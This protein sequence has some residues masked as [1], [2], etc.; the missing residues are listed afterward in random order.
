VTAEQCDSSEQCV[1]GVCLIPPLMAVAPELTPAE[2]GQPYEAEFQATGGVPPYRW[3]VVE[4][5]L[6]RGLSLSRR[7]YLSGI[8]WTAGTWPFTAEVTDDQGETSSVSVEL[9]VWSLGGQVEITTTALPEASH[10]YEYARQLEAV[11]GAEPYAWQV[12]EGLLPAGMTLSSDG[13]LSGVPSEIG[14]FPL[15]FRVIDGATPPTYDSRE[16]PLVVE[17]SP[18][19][20]TGDREY[21]LLVTKIIILGI[22]VP[23]IPYSGNLEARGGLTPYQWE[24][25]DLPRALRLLVGSGGLPDGLTLDSDGRLAGWVTDVSDAVTVNLPF[26]GPELAGYFFSA[27]VTDSQSPADSDEAIFCIPTV[28][29]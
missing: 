26:G 11:G 7:G 3:A 16:L 25:N 13:L 17:V 27:E 20:I 29:F 8:P 12:L 15:M 14:S 1:D 21:N 4:G 5:V 6:P 22:L 19:E 18:L 24:E 23:Y 2:E 10:G 28:S 9:F